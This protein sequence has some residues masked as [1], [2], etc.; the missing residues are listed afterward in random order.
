MQEI[1][2]FDIYGSVYSLPCLLI[3][4][5]KDTLTLITDT[6]PV[7]IPY[8]KILFFCYTNKLVERNLQ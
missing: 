5:D 1:T 8:E 6:K 3:I 7:L 4:L 2:L